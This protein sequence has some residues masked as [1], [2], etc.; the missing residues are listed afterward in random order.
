MKYFK[1]RLPEN[2]RI[3]S[4]DKLNLTSAEL[5]ILAW[6]PEVIIVSRKKLFILLDNSTG[7]RYEQIRD[8]PAG[9]P[10]SPT[11]LIR[12]KIREYLQMLMIENALSLAMTD[13]VFLQLGWLKNDLEEW[14]D[15]WLHINDEVY[16]IDITTGTTGWELKIGRMP[17]NQAKHKRTIIAVECERW[18]YSALY[19]LLR[20]SWA[21]EDAQQLK[22]ILLDWI[23]KLSYK[24]HIT[25][26]NPWSLQKT[27]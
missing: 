16:P 10:M 2:D 9:L 19:T 25:V 4:P 3:G 20:K 6:I 17:E 7:A 13:R 14:I 15:A 23:L 5:T 22:R 11:Q 1:W 8:N 18:I 27:P 24:I 21:V 26:M 12:Q